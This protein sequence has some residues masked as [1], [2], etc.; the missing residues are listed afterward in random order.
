MLKKQLLF[1]STFLLWTTC[2][3][4]QSFEGIITYKMEAQNPNPEMIPDSVFQQG[5]KETS[6]ERGYM[7]QTYYYKGENYMSEID[8][9][10]QKGFQLY[11]PGDGLLYSWQEGTDEAITVDSKKFM[12]ELVEITASEETEV[13]LGFTCN[14]LDIKSKFGETSVWFVAEEFIM[15]PAPF[16]DHLYGHWGP[17]LQKTGAIPLK[18]EMKGFMGH[19]IQTAIEHEATT[20]DN[21]R[22]A[23]PEFNEVTANPMN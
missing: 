9:G 3:I 11:N 19:F 5:L 10:T 21:S 16:K 13:I 23:L 7:V 22:F 20:I 2:L 18:I 6:G 14:R 17:I 8:A 1:W 15:D 4:G 12:D